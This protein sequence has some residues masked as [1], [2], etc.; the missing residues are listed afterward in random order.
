MSDSDLSSQKSIESRY[1]ERFKSLAKSSS[2]DDE[3]LSEMIKKKREQLFYG[4][5][6][7][8]SSHKEATFDLSDSYY[9]KSSQSQHS[10]LE[11]RI[12]KLEKDF[13][14]S[15]NSTQKKQA[16][17]QNSSIQ[18]YTIDTR[19]FEQRDPVNYQ[20]RLKELKQ[21]DNREPPVDWRNQ[22]K[23]DN[24]N[25]DIQQL[26]EELER[27]KEE[28]EYQSNNERATRQK[29]K[30]KIGGQQKT[31]QSKKSRVQIQEEQIDNQ[32]IFTNNEQQ[33][34]I[35]D[36]KI[37]KQLEELKKEFM[38]DNSKQQ[39]Q[40]VQ[41]N[42][43]KLNSD[44]KSNKRQDTQK[45]QQE[46]NKN[47]S[48]HSRNQS[49]DLVAKKQEK[50]HIEKEKEKENKYISKDNMQLPSSP[51]KKLDKQIEVLKQIERIRHK[52]KKS[53]KRKIS[54]ERIIEQEILIIRQYD[55]SYNMQAKTKIL[56]K[57]TRQHCPNCA[58]LL[59]KGMSTAFCSCN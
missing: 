45:S 44:I 41:D 30:Q 15:I 16:S 47:D 23:I 18:S 50:V 46:N 3:S 17:P 55:P 32:P 10:N 13:S 25:H 38:L 40:E 42:I 43:D 11:S 58:Y 27:L 49:L 39:I 53:I 1:D 37:R 57:S 31:E 52:L 4:Q 59:N 54:E 12:K 36:Q 14:M 8:T 26:Q 6:I 7:K 19:Q 29:L 24:F 2:E 28:V 34:D 21:Y 20:R 48:N 5:N 56:P 35:M 22:R 9:S 51:L 33:E